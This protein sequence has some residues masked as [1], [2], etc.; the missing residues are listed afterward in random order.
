M[1][2]NKSLIAKKLDF[3]NQNIA[4]IE[5]MDFDKA[6]FIKNSDTHDLVVFRLQ[7]AVETCIDITTH[8]IAESDF[9]RKETAKDAFLLLG[10]VG[11]IDEELVLKLGKAADFR[12]RVVHGYNDFD[13][14][15]L[16]EDFKD[17]IGDLRNF[18]AQIIQFLEKQK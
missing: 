8:L 14:S 1:P 16:Y 5:R 18:G 15:L 3:L 13:Y 12:N 7:Q 10:E 9:P 17:N 2:I 4:A 11:I 6:S